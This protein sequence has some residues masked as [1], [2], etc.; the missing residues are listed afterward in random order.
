MDE[1][2]VGAMLGLLEMKWVPL[3]GG[4]AVAATV[5]LS[6]ANAETLPL[7]QPSSSP[8]VEVT[9]ARHE[10]SPQDSALPADTPAAEHQPPA[11][12]LRVSNAY[13]PTD[14]GATTPS[15][16]AD[17]AKVNLLAYV[18][19]PIQGY[20]GTEE[21][22][23]AFTSHQAVM[24]L[25][26]NNRNIPLQ[27]E[28]LRRAYWTLPATE[29]MEL[30]VALQGY[31]QSVGNDPYR[32]FSLG[33]TKL[34]MADNQSGLFYLRKANDAINN[35]FTRLVYGAAQ[36]GVDMRQEQAK[37]DDWTIRKQNAVFMINDGVQAHGV[38]PLPGFWPAYQRVT[39]LLAP[40]PA[41]TEAMTTDIS[42]LM[43]P[44]GDS[45]ALAYVKLAA[46]TSQLTAAAIADS[47]EATVMAATEIAPVTPATCQRPTAAPS[48]LASANRQVY[49]QVDGQGGLE[50]VAVMP[51]DEA[52]KPSVMVV[53][54]DTYQQLGRFTAKK[55][56]YVF[57]D[58]D[59]DGL[60]E[61]VIRQGG[62]HPERPV[63]VY[64]YDGCQY[65][66]DTKTAALF[67]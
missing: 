1:K 57:E 15:R 55:A 3:V 32:F 14:S 33:V 47:T 5:G 2:V 8:A 39:Q 16:Q 6:S 50:T 9:E 23:A 7:P 18:S 29:Q 59:S 10:P 49:V 63:L 27:F 21:I 58:L 65:V 36:A 11:T 43:V 24:S 54:N 60:P 44:Y 66:M 67:D 53:V 34:L 41:Y 52:S 13:Q 31:H 30:L 17:I 26:S 46:A 35:S 28:V 45:V 4:M 61:V 12:E 48:Q 56:P 19:V 51:N 22:P 25:L 20:L 38:N 42:D 62:T 37:P 64:R 40:L